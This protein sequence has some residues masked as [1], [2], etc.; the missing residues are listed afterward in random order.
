M[1]VEKPQH[2]FFLLIL[3]HNVI[4]SCNP[5]PNKKKKNH[6]VLEVSADVGHGVI[7]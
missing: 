1:A 6:K 5:I 7:V 3:R 4:T 2:S